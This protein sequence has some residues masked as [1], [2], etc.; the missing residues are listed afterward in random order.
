MSINWQQL[1]DET[2]KIEKDVL[3]LSQEWMKQHPDWTG[4]VFFC[5]Y[6]PRFVLKLEILHINRLSDKRK[7]EVGC[8]VTD[9]C[10]KFG[11][12]GKKIWGS[13]YKTNQV[14]YKLYLPIH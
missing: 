1:T 14:E 13:D 4:E 9:L 3:Q 12:K 6:P 7:D 11:L 5:N 8:L 2:R 10:N